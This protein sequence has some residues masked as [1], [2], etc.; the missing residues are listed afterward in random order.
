MHVYTR[1]Q[2]LCEATLTYAELVHKKLQQAG[3]YDNVGQFDVT[4]QARAV[5][6]YT[7]LFTIMADKKKHKT[8]ISTRTRERKQN[9]LT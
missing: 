4:N 7:S 5:P 1:V 6:L 9:E 3:Y 2:T 8:C